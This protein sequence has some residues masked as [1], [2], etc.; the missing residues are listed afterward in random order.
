MLRIPVYT[1][2]LAGDVL[3]RLAKHHI[4]RVFIV[5]SLLTMRVVGLVTLRDV[6]L[7]ILT[8]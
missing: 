4:H 5:D 3:E 2:T 8:E 1:L 7:Q 6:L